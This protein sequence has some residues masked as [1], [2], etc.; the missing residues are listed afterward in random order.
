[1]RHSLALVTIRP[2]LDCGTHTTNPTR[3][4][5]CSTLQQQATD[6][7]RGNTTQRNYGAPWAKLSTTVITRDG[8]CT[9]CGTTGTPTNPLTAD[10]IIPKARGGTD[11]LHNL[12]CRCRR[13]N[14]AKGTT[15]T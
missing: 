5:P 1:M 3:C 15:L 2:C 7:R 8:H 13:H 11:D 14:S 10:H 12:I 4:P 9:D 6:K